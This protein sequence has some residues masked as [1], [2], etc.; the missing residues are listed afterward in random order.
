M[1]SSTDCLA[2]LKNADF[3][4]LS[5]LIEWILSLRPP[6]CF[7]S[8]R[9][10]RRQLTD[11]LNEGTPS[12]L[13]AAPYSKIYRI[14]DLNSKGKLCYV[15][16]REMAIPDTTRTARGVCRHSRRTASTAVLSVVAALALAVTGN[17][18]AGGSD[19][20]P[21]SSAGLPDAGAASAVTSSSQPPG[22]NEASSLEAA[23][24]QAATAIANA[25]QNNVQNIVVIIRI[26]SPG[27]DVISQS[28][29]AT[30]GAVAANTSMTDQA[31]GTSAPTDQ[32]EPTAST[33]TPTD[34]SSGGE[35][36]AAP[37]PAVT[38]PAPT[39]AGAEPPAATLALRVATPGPARARPRVA[40]VRR[41]SGD[42]ADAS[43]P[44]AGATHSSAA[45]VRTGSKPDQDAA[46]TQVAPRQVA[47]AVPRS[48]SAPSARDSQPSVTSVPARIGR[49]AARAGAG[50]AHLVGGLAPRPSLQVSSAE[51]ADSVSTAVVM[52]LLAVVLA[53][54]LGVGSTYVPAI[55]VRA[56]R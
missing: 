49:A 9:Y 5:P 12:P 39:P 44:G 38:P 13:C 4:P 42:R 23:T 19:S 10:W 31:S 14:R 6:A 15:R 22:S 28:N 34:G 54:L 45:Q 55:R 32:A 51:K 2:Q 27:D 21:D 33:V 48:A 25:T 37:P 56:W 47:V 1:R 50:T 16:P 52:A 7:K 3:Q 35:T 8:S 18:F 40:A 46:M 11:K 20:L 24:Q 26:N 53:V 36:P 41:A 29:T 30:A 17:A 43:G